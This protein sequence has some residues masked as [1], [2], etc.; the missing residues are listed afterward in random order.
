[1]AYRNSHLNIVDC[2]TAG[3]TVVDLTVKMVVVNLHI[4]CFEA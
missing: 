3:E 4:E 1:V 2:L